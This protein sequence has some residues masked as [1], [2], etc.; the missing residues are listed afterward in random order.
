VLPAQVADVIAEAASIA[1]AGGLEAAF[2][3]HAGTGLVR[4]VLG[5]G[6]GLPDVAGTLGRWRALARARGGQALLE[7]APLALKE[8][9]PVWDAPGPALR[10]MQ[11]IKAEL[12]PRGVLNPGRFVGGI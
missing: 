10:V 6:E 8:R 11:R 3:A 12:D 5:G 7:S 2:V 1:G 9:V 4:G